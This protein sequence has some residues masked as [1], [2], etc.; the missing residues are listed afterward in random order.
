MDFR[1]VREADGGT[2]FCWAKNDVGT[3]D[4]LSMTFDVLFPPRQVL[5]E[6]VKFADFDVG[7]N[8]QFKCDAE[9]NPP[10]KFEWLQKFPDLDNSKGQV[11]SRGFGKALSLQ[12]VTY[13]HEGTWACV[14][15]TTIKG[16]ER[17]VTSEPITVEV[18]GKPQVL[19]FKTDASQDFPL[20]SNAIIKASFCSDP[21]PRSLMWQWGSL[22]LIE[23][24]VFMVHSNNELFF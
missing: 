18:V 6:P 24:M 10:A 15:T 17:K 1:P 20:H 21:K 9:S 12:N 8:A 11:F 16:R 5:T 19:A 23:G 13:E 2:Y 3:S 14:A 4:E 7:K 22:R